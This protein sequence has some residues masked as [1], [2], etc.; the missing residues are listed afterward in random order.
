MLGRRVGQVVTRR[1]GRR[2]GA[3]LVQ[4]GGRGRTV[5]VRAG[6]SVMVS[7][8]TAIGARID[9]GRGMSFQGSGIGLLALEDARGETGGIFV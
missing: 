4:G 2:T 8:G 9:G 5:G 1:D 7:T 3:G 6:A